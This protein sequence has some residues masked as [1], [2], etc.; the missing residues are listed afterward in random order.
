M[1]RSKMLD[2]MTCTILA[3]SSTY[4][5]FPLENLLTLAEELLKQQ[6][7]FGML[8]PLTAEDSM[9]HPTLDVKWED[10]ND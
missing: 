2:E 10:E 7:S 1:K 6:E 8:P 4:P 5:Q 3:H 9:W